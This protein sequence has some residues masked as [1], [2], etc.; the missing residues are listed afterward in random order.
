MSKLVFFLIGF[1][2]VILYSLVNKE[3]KSIV[4]ISFTFVI[5]SRILF[6]YKKDMKK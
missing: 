6:D 5:L 4:L 3:Y 2:I 1:L